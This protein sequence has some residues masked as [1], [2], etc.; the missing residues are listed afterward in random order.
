MLITQL[1]ARKGFHR[2]TLDEI[3]GRAGLTKGVVY[4]NF[5]SRDVLFLAVVAANSRDRLKEFPWSI[6]RRGSLR[7]RLGHLTDAVISQT[8]NWTTDAPLRAEFLLYTLSHPDMT[9]RLSRI[10]GDRIA[11]VR[12]KLRQSIDDTE[13]PVSPE[14][15]VLLLE[16]LL[17]GLMYIRAQV[18][19][20]M[21]DDSIC[22][23]LMSFAGKR[24]RSHG[25][26][27]V[28]INNGELPLQSGRYTSALLHCTVSGRFA[29]ISMRSKP[30]R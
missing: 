27:K 3:V 2:A 7:T 23:I 4:D 19:T 9:E 12:E 26:Y 15:F 11:F 29:A 30:Q 18:A 10:Y 14:R 22:E 1:F 6:S 20:L 13:L 21:T 24:T 28:N 17:P 5:E 16:A 8:P 25:S